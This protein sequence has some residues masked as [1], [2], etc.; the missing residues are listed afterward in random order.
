MENHK[1]T[2]PCLPWQCPRPNVNYII[3][4]ICT[5][6]RLI[7]STALL[8]AVVPFFV[9]LLQLP[10]LTTIFGWCGGVVERWEYGQTMTPHTSNIGEMTKVCECEK[11]ASV[12]RREAL[13]GSQNTQSLNLLKMI[14]G[15]YFKRFFGAIN[16][17]IATT[18]SNN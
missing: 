13:G 15:D 6:Y 10:C 16:E 12:V 18:Q 4:S 11:V 1:E 7:L 2:L 3:Q 8:D 5:Q 9:F 17:F 14:F